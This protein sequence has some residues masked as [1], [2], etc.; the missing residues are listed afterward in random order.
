MVS[1]C[2][3]LLSLLS[4]CAWSA[5]D[6]E[7][8]VVEGESLTGSKDGGTEILLPRIRHGSLLVTAERGRVDAARDLLFLY[9]RVKIVDSTRAINADEGTYR[10]ST[11]V[12]DLVGH[13]VGDGAEGHLEAG[14]LNYDRMAGILRLRDHPV[15]DD[16]LR[17][18]RAERIDY[19]RDS[20][21]AIAT[22]KVAILLKE[23]STWV[24]GREARYRDLTG[25]MVVTGDPWIESP[26]A[27]GD[28]S[29]V[30][31]AD[32]LLLFQHE[33]R[34]EALGH[35]RI[36]RGAVHARGGHAD[37][38]FQENRV[39]LTED[40][41]AWESEGEIVADTLAITL[42]Q[43]RPDRLRAIRNVRVRYQPPDKPGET[44]VILGDTLVANLAGDRMSGLEVQGNAVSLYLPG[45]RD[46]K[47]G[48]G[49]NVSQ[50]RR[51]RVD[52]VRGEARSIELLENASGTY[53]YPGEK[54]VGLLHNQ[55]AM[56]SLRAPG[57]DSVRGWPRPLAPLE[58]HFVATRGLQIPDSIATPYDALFDQKV[59]Y[60]ADTIR[61]YVGED[62]I[63]LL[64]HG[65]IQYGD[66]GLESG[67][68][69]YFAKRELVLANADP[70]LKDANSEVHGRR[71]SYRT[72]LKEGF[73]YQGRTEFD[74][75]FYR[76]EQ[77][78]KLADNALL[79]KNGD[80]TTC[81][82]DPPHYEFHSSRMKLIKDDK[83]VARPVVL[84]ILDVPVMVLP[85]YFFPLKKGRHSGLLLPRVE[86]GFNQYRGRFLRN[87][88][89]YWAMSDYMDGSAWV[90][91]NENDNELI[92]NSEYRY[93]VRYLL[94][95]SARGS[96]SSSSVPGGRT[97]RYSVQGQH[98]QTL[99]DT[100]R[101][102]ANANFVSD[103]TFRSDRDFGSGVDELLNRHID[104]SLGLTKTW[105][106]ATSSLNIVR[107][108]YLDS[109]TAAGEKVHWEPRV[110]F[111]F[112]QRQLGRAPDARGHG[113]RLPFLATT[114]VNTGLQFRAIDISRW[115]GTH[116]KNEAAQQSFGLSDTRSLGPYLRLNPSVSGSAAW[117][118]KDARGERN[119]AGATWS[120]RAGAKNDLYGTWQWEKSRL[121]GVRHVVTP[122]VSYSY[123]PEI[124][125]L[126]YVDTLG[127]RRSRFGSV[128]GIGLSGSKSSFMSMSLSQR[129]H[130]KFRNGN[131]IVKK[132]NVLSWDTSTSYNF[133][134]KGKTKP[135]TSITNSLQLRPY[136]L[137]NVSSSW[138]HNPYTRAPERFSVQSTLSLSSSLF[139]GG[140]ADSG[141]TSPGLQYGGF[142]DSF[143]SQGKGSTFSNGPAGPAWNLSLSHSYSTQ[144]GATRPTNTMNVGL[145]F[146]PTRNWAFDGSTYLDLER[147]EVTTHSFSL[148]RNLHCWEFSFSHI[149]RGA[150]S[151]YSF[152][153]NLKEL[154]DVQY[155]REK[156]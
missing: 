57:A 82:A 145:R 56:E 92:F 50:A 74:G 103:Q 14:Q 62:R 97:H 142:G 106:G 90:D 64:G 42:E 109:L 99:S 68:I 67:D 136:S 128:G 31:R 6:E 120:A 22:G 112:N 23:D 134:A 95:G 47:S 17:I 19:F 85:Y 49:R 84:R 65:K 36:D 123:A 141:G 119:Q 77:V 104:S 30:V 148:H 144:R 7:A 140:A 63:R 137:F 9:Q 18:I 54:A 43:G 113:A 52:L 88:G 72:D 114:Y 94:D 86:F 34:G 129:L 40:P 100:A 60:S 76:G 91:V 89:Y 61:F 111:N 78:K 132:E 135:L 35:V 55:A 38:R 4:L 79:V 153:I 73:V 29:L 127:V 147:K 58:A 110:D 33:S 150:Q 155:T 138:S 66:S 156:R 107:N 10:R 11:R 53:L 12:L 83:V 26:G 5:T 45:E 69:E 81:D 80:Y 143:Q 101:L 15:L 108:E 125:S 51:I 93:A 21:I 139:A 75:G 39:L 115:N 3:L 87:L 32:T 102:T 133:L 24:Y 2:L 131:Q 146:S 13:V 8:W 105:N 16:S 20:L 41:L 126:T 71:M 1:A 44:N 27:G 116:T 37:F 70:V 59:E 98:R 118:A 122:S 117:F 124:K 130:L 46:V 25:E 152:R 48:S 149:T 121:A 96:Y 28:S 154:Q 151:E